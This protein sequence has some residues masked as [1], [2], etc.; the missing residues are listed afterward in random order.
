METGASAGARAGLTVAAGATAGRLTVNDTGAEAA[1]TLPARSV[2]L[3][4]NVCVPSETDATGWPAEH[5]ANA[6][7]SRLHDHAAPPSVGDENANVG[8]PLTVAPLAGAL[9]TGVAGATVSRASVSWSAATPSPTSRL[10]FGSV[11][12]APIRSNPVA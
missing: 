5:G 6:P 2:A 4:D 12:S 9:M 7:P 3:T 10:P 1:L 8:A 11:L